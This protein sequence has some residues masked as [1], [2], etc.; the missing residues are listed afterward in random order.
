MVTLNGE[1]PCVE[2]FG[3][4]EAE[5]YEM[6]NNDFTRYQNFA[7]N[8]LFKSFRLRLQ[9][10]KENYNNQDYIKYECKSIKRIANSY[11]YWTQ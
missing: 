10:Q 1:E 6:M 8:M 2:I 3:M 11:S 9:A 7:R 4:K 5:L